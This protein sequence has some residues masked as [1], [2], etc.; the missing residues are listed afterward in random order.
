MQK[1]IIF[2]KNLKKHRIYILI[3]V[4][5]KDCNNK[6]RNIVK[7]VLK[8]NGYTYEKPKLYIKKINN[9]INNQ[10][11]EEYNICLKIATELLSEN[12]SKY[13]IKDIL[14]KIELQIITV[15]Y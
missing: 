8:E 2:N 10:L 1:N 5:H 13:S 12:L 3:P 15:I 11:N 14:R 4:I 7:K 6:I 9:C